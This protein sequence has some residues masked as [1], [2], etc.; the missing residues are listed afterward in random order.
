MSYS[1][2]F[3][4]KVTGQRI[5]SAIPFKYSLSEDIP[6]I[7]FPEMRVD[8]K[9]VISL[10]DE[11]TPIKFH[12][13]SLISFLQDNSITIGAKDA[14]GRDISKYLKESS[15]H[16]ISAYLL[17][18]P[19]KCPVPLKIGFEAL[20]NLGEILFLFRISRITRLA[21]SHTP[22]TLHIT[23]LEETDALRPVFGVTKKKSDEFRSALH[24]IL[25]RIDGSDGVK[26]RSLAEVVSG[27]K[28]EYQKELDLQIGQMK[29][30]MKANEASLQAVIPTIALSL[31]LSKFTLLDQRD[32][33]LELFSKETI[34][35][36]D[37]PTLFST[38][39]GYLSY[40]EVVN[41]NIK[42]T[43]LKSQL[44]LSLHGSQRAFGIRATPSMSNIL[45]H[46]GVP[47]VCVKDG[48]K[49]FEMLYF[50]DFLK[51]SEGK[52]TTKICDPD[53]NFLY[54]EQKL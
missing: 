6:N 9:E 32:F 27:S 11:L 26:I 7:S 33:L 17:C 48:Q 36:D 35:E 50:V 15:G 34:S 8:F 40:L 10:C 2:T 12:H 22:L 30:E 14:I 38:A 53:G 13:G 23:L 47:V 31:Q 18:L 46:H 16:T 49:S 25:E 51:E 39:V 43:A 1:I 5:S 41:K 45:P 52:N 42:D 19:F 37:Y 54:F 21:S 24:R 20:P 3:S 44:K 4:Q 29:K 28:A